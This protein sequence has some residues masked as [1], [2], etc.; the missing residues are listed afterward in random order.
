[1]VNVN[2]I[3]AATYAGAALP[4]LRRS[5]SGSIVNV[6]SCYGVTGRKGMGIYDA[7]KVG[8]LAL[9]RTLA[10]EEAE[11]GVRVNAVGQGRGQGQK[12][13]HPENRAAG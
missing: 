11:H 4:H 3:G 13:R 7:T 5:G 9:T 12:R 10:H 1:M 2:L 8:Q 6:S